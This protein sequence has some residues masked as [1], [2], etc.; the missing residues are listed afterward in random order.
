MVDARGDEDHVVTI[1]GDA[2][3][4]GGIEAREL[5]AE[6]SGP[7][8]GARL[9]DVPLDHVGAGDLDRDTAYFSFSREMSAEL[10]VTGGD[11]EHARGA[12][13]PPVRPLGVGEEGAREAAI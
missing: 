11:L 3:H 7:G 4:V 13:A 2:V 6:P 12:A 5:E 9:V 1:V 8:A 10:P